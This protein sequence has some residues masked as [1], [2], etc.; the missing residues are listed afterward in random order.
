MDIS[1]TEITFNEKGVCNFCTTWDEKERERKARKLH[2]GLHWML[3]EIEKQ[4]GKY[5]VLC[6]LSG[7]VDSAMVLHHA[8]ERGLKPLCFSIDNGF[9]SSGSDENIMRMV[10]KLKVPFFRYTIDLKEFSD[11]LISFVRAGIKNIEVGTDHI[12]MASTYKMASQHG[13]KFIL[14][15]GNHSG[16]GVM[17]ESFGENASDLRFIK[18]VF[19]K[20]MGRKLNSKKLPTISLLKYLYFRFV[21]GIK[22]INWLDLHEYNRAESIKILEKEYG[23]KPY[24]EKHCESKLTAW[25]QNFYLPTKF[26]I[27][28][29]RPHYSSMI[30]SGQMTKQEALEK[31]KEPLRYVPFGNEEKVLKY[32]ISKKNYGDYPNSY[33]LRKQLSKI[34]GIVRR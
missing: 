29:R 5:N 33:K 25:F 20:Q 24:G 18:S 1:A 16:E 32:P 34:Y 19:K 30:C 26:G 6:G 28:K 22:I 9:N 15:G 14:S 23:W 27:D 3:Y 10:E 17:P 11:L 12:L 13:I 2:P 31:L 7:G 8:M 21:K 4:K